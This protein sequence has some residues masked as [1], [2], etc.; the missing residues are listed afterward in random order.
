MLGALWRDD[1]DILGHGHTQ[2]V[3]YKLL[4][5]RN[6]VSVYRRDG[7]YIQGDVNNRD[8]CCSPCYPVYNLDD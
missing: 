6:L 1:D 7:F 8:S 3:K 5:W 4:G 2:D